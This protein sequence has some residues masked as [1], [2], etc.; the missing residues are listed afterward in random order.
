MNAE[1]IMTRLHSKGFLCYIVGGAVRD[2][3]LGLEQ[4]DIDLATSAST[5]EVELLF[6][7]AE[8][9]TVGKK[10]GVV[11]VDNIEVASFRG[12]KYLIPGKP[13]VQRVGTFTEDAARRDF[14][15]NAMAL[16][17]QG[18]L[19]D[20]FQGKADLEHKLVRAVGDPILRFTEDPIRI[21]R[22][23]GFAVRFGFNIETQ[24]RVAMQQT[25]TLLESVPKIRIGRELQKLSKANC[26]AAGLRLIE[27][28]ELLPVVLPQLGHLPKV[29]QNP[30][31]HHLNAWNHSLAV[32]EYI[33]QL[34]PEMKSEDLVWAALFHD[35][36]KG[37]PGIRAYH[38]KSKQPSDHGHNEKSTTLT[39]EALTEWA[40]PKPLKRRVLFLVRHHMLL[41]RGT[42][43]EDL[44]AFLNELAEDFNSLREMQMNYRKLFWLKMAD[45]HGKADFHRLEDIEN[46]TEI[47]RKLDIILGKVPF[48]LNQTSIKASDFSE[49]GEDLGARIRQSLLEEQRNVLRSLD[50]PRLFEK[51]E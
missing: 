21:L 23:I 17:L 2:Q 33:E 37:L 47:W 16:D 11:L 9:R 15:I 38:E 12:E 48:F 14:T 51:A 8:V 49:T 39:E 34:P 3:L 4:F 1:Q 25:R 27:Q 6:A 44:V 30:K 35:C 46:L 20:P 29:E 24:T 36:G 41:P 42:K 28:L 31:Y 50:W 26:L 7:D 19:H 5:E 13:E 22:G 40:F 43:A 45:V 32:L 10:F 18:K